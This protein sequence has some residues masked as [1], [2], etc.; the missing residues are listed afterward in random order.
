LISAILVTYKRPQLLAEQ[1]E[2]VRSQVDEIIIT[3]EVNE[4]TSKF[5]FSG[6]DKLITYDTNISHLK[7][8]FWS[9]LAADNEYVVILDD[10]IIPGR[11]WISS[12]MKHKLGVYGSWGIILRDNL[13]HNRRVV[14]NHIQVDM[15]GHSWFMPTKYI[16][17]IFREQVPSW[18][19]HADD[20]WVAYRMQQADIPLYVVPGGNIRE[21]QVD[22]VALSTRTDHMGERDRIVRKLIDK[23]WELLYV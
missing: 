20:L 19:H 7:Q 16:A 15:I 23:G 3:H 6:Y 9:A 5:N 11:N 17:Y 10:D 13:Y 1:V 18:C 14:A 8:K 4:V 12:C 2:H 22:K 21:P